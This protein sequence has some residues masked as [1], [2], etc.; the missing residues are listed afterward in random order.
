M[1]IRQNKLITCL[2][3]LL[4][5][6]LFRDN[7]FVLGQNVKCSEILMWDCKKVTAVQSTTNYIKGHCD[8]QLTKLY[9]ALAGELL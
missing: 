8:R 3:P 5:L 1:R 9:L 2:E 4:I 6:Q 7:K